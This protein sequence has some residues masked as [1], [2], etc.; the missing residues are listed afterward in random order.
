MDLDLENLSMNVRAQA[1]V[2]ATQSQSISNTILR[3]H[4]LLACHTEQIF[5]IFL[6]REGL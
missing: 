2:M 5:P 3:K 4:K 6:D 1:I